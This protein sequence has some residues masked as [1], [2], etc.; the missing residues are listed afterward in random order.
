[1]QVE[2]NLHST[3]KS[4]R[5]FST[6]AAAV[7]AGILTSL[8]LA[9]TAARAQEGGATA[10]SKLTGITRAPAG[11]D[12][13]LRAGPLI[14]NPDE[15]LLQS[16]DS[17]AGPWWTVP[18]QTRNAV[19]DGYE[20]VTPFRPWLPRQFYRLGTLR[21]SSTPDAASNAPRIQRVTPNAA[22]KPGQSIALMGYNFSP[23]P[24]ANAVTFSLPNGS[25]NAVVTAATDRALVLTVPANLTSPGPF[26]PELLYRI[27]VTTADGVSNGVGCSVKNA[28]VTAFALRPQLAYVLLSPGSGMDTMVVGG[29]TPPYTLKPQTP[30]EAARATAT[31]NGN[32]LNLV[33]PP[34][35][36]AGAISVTVNDSSVPPRS[37]QALASVVSATFTPFLWTEFHTRL[38][39]SSPGCTMRLSQFGGLPVETTEV[40]LQGATVHTAALAPGDIAAVVQVPT[41]LDTLHAH[42]EVTEKESGI[43]RFEVVTMTDGVREVLATGSLNENPAAF[44][45]HTGG[46]P[47]GSPLVASQEQEIIFAEGIFRLPAGV[48]TPFSLIQSMTSVSTSEERY[49]PLRYTRTESLTTL[50]STGPRLE[51]VVPGQAQASAFVKLK[52]TGMGADS[53]VT[54]ASLDDTRVPAAITRVPAV[55]KERTAEGLTVVVPQEANIGGPVEVT[56]G[57]QVSNGFLFTP[58]FHPGALMQFDTLQAGTP[59]TWHLRW[60]QLHNADTIEVRIA[61]IVWTLDAGSFD[62]SG[63]TLNQDAGTRH[64]TTKDTSFT[65]TQDIYYAGP[66][67]GTGRHVFG[68]QFVTFYLSN[69]PGGAGV[70]ITAELS[71]EAW[72]RSLVWDGHFTTALYQPP[73]A[74]ST[75]NTGMEIISR[76]WRSFVFPPM[77]VT[78]N[79]SQQVAP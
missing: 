1:M 65:N 34:G 23:V 43:A 68:S 14:P 59:A 15:L 37:A 64:V 32:L 46:L 12:L 51:S 28:A 39:G 10:A 57:G 67:P 58:R 76:Q 56:S 50:G 7:A 48:G 40:F 31:L 72:R 45:L 78:K 33:A 71:T 38:E 27:S 11:G 79:F 30:A 25:W 44:V 36:T 35:A 41:G 66:E 20:F 17:P 47:P 61:R 70:I 42:I 69:A 18:D 2:T 29:G 19:A 8:L 63:L 21:F 5:L 26:D 54:F 4:V 75:L 74:G 3:M 13:L 52:G 16:A 6:R 9:V 60:Q 53:V 55:I 24:S 77:T 73:P 49:A 62:F 22:V